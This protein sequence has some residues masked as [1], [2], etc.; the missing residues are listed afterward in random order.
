[1]SKNNRQD[2]FVLFVCL[3]NFVWHQYLVLIMR[4]FKTVLLF[5]KAIINLFYDTTFV[6][7]KVKKQIK[8]FNVA[9][10]AFS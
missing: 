5:K 2:I 9:S 3:K 6:W 7:I 10:N 4:H 1:M 8:S